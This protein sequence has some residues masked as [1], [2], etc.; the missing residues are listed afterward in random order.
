MLNVR[1]RVTITHLPL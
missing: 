1:Y